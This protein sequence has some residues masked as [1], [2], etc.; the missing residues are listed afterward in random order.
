MQQLRAGPK[1]LDTARE[2]GAGFERVFISA[3]GEADYLRGRRVTGEAGTDLRRR[4]ELYSLAR[5]GATLAILGRENPPALRAL[6]ARLEAWALALRPEA[7]CLL[8]AA[9][10]SVTEDAEAAAA[11][12]AVLTTTDDATKIDRAIQEQAESVA[13]E[14]QVLIALHQVRQVV[15]ATRKRTLVASGVIQRRAVTP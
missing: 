9:Q 11:L 7:A 5:I 3:F 12:M 15:R 6:F 10:V 13:S 2:D 14:Q 8:T 4:P 1:A